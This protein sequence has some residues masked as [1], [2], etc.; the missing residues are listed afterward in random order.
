MQTT[1]NDGIKEKS[2]TTIYAKSA[3]KIFN[4]RKTFKE[5]KKQIQLIFFFSWYPINLP[6][7]LTKNIC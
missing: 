7:T 1:M 4:Y 5:K 2:K 3:E 6:K